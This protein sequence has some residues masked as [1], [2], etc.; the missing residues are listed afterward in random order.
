VI[1]DLPFGFEIIVAAVV[2]A[3]IGSFLNVCILRWGSE[4]KQSVVRPRSRCPRCGRGLAWYDNIPVISWIVL[5]ARCRSCGQPISAMYPLIELATAGIWAFIVWRYGVSLEA[6][7][8]AIFATIL[9]GIAVTDAREFI[10]PHEF[11]IGGTAL[12]IL[13]S[14][15]SEPSNALVSIQGALLGA[16]AVLLIGELSGLILGQEAMG[17]GDCALMGMIGAFL[18]WEAVFPVLLVGAV[19]STVI[20]LIAAVWPPRSATTASF[21][22]PEIAP[23]P[24]PFRWALVARL[25]AAGAVPIGILIVSEALGQTGE[26][27]TAV[28]HGLLGA[29]IAYYGFFILPVRVSGQWWV[30][31]AGF[32]AAAVAI[33]LGAGLSATRMA[34]GIALA[35]AGLWL[36]R[37]THLVPT[38][39]TTAGLQSQGYLPYGVG[40]TIAA[41]LLQFSGAMPLV[42]DVVLEYGRLLGM[43]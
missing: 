28:F 40:L 4:P 21:V 33:A 15:W 31:V 19:I 10:I 36:A 32:L 11:S 27:L 5:R 7:R 24:R 34:I 22:E 9:L 37:Q 23:A 13:L 8:A 2:G 42:R 41:G 14:G 35:L 25:F 30:R 16:G 6:L 26:V 3:M 18:G 17:G 29:G 1:S 39:E 20:F 12:A 43:A 38:P